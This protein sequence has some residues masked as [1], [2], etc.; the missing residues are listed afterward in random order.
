M[1][2][3]ITGTNRGIGFELTRQALARGDEVDAAARRPEGARALGELA[4]KYGDRLRLHA[5]DVT[6]DPSVRAF[7]AGLAPGR[8]D[9]VLNNAGVMGKLTSLEDLDMADAVETF[10]VNALGPLR[11]SKALLPRLEHGAK[12]VHITSGMGSI[13]DNT[14]GGAYAYRMAKAA[15]NMASR[16]MAVDLRGR[17]MLSVVVNPGWVKTDMGGAGAPLPV[18]TSA[19]NI[20]RLIDGL[21]AEQ[22]GAFLDHSGSEW[23]F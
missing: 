6:S 2:W 23:P 13:T 21:R 5:C 3:V 14:S 16:S 12:L 19:A 15:L 17:G 22:S 11:V 8:I 20:L 10:E 4:A 7:V 18:E 1:R 9:V